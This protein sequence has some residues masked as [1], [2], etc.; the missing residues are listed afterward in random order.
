M[1]R[2]LQKKLISLPNIVGQQRKIVFREP[3]KHSFYHFEDTSI[4]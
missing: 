4:L 1:E 2:T 3:L